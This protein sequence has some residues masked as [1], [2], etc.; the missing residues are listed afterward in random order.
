MTY[1]VNWIRSDDAFP[2]RT[3][4]WVTIYVGEQLYIESP[5]RPTDHQ[6]DHPPGERQVRVRGRWTHTGAFQMF[7]GAGRVARLVHF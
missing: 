2:G 6:I 7:A 4:G 3:W 5:D 1:G